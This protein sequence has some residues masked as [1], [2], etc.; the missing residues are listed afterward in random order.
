MAFQ[1]FAAIGRIF[2][3]A[4]KTAVNTTAEVASRT[5]KTAAQATTKSVTTPSVSTSPSVAPSTPSREAVVS[6]NP[7]IRPNK[8]EKNKNSVLGAVYDGL[9]L[10]RNEFVET[11]ANKVAGWMKRL[12]SR[13]PEAFGEATHKSG[14]G[15]IPLTSAIYQ[16]KDQSYMVAASDGISDYGPKRLS[17]SEVKTLQSLPADKEKQTEFRSQV[18]ERHLSGEIEQTR[19]QGYS[20]SR[21]THMKR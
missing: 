12:A 15:S 19:N 14:T 2:S 21:D 9:Q 20:Q 16:V 11:L 3:T 5:A 4:G 10:P 13:A 1:I 8:S 17:Q 6:R 18:T 7:V